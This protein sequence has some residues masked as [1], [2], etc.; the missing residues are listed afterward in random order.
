MYQRILLPSD[1]SAISRQAVASG[2]RF[3]RD[4]GA[5]V[6]GIHVLPQPHP[7]QLQAWMHHDPH[8]E[9]K[10]RALFDKFADESL[11]FIANS[12][13]AE[14]VPCSYHKL[15]SSQPW[16]AIVKAA[17][18]ERCDLIFMA[19][20]GW[21][22]GEGELPGSETRKVLH[23]SAVPVLVFKASSGQAAI[24]PAAARK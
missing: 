13:L 5:S 2:I 6:V 12:A 17:Q 9:E 15:E 16:Q 19:S 14:G 11:A 21:H 24:A 20:H 4:T 8:Y 23:H 7:D 18:Q 22:G 1:G 10:R 3:A